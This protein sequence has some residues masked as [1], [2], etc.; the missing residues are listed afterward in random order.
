MNLAN[1]NFY[2]LMTLIGLEPG[3]Y[4]SGDSYPSDILKAIPEDF[5]GFDC[6]QFAEDYVADRLE[7]I[8]G[9]AKEAQRRNE[10]V[11]WG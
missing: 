9:I 1:G 6:G 5:D 11:C 8:R 10:L 3:E 2:G 4:L 7:V